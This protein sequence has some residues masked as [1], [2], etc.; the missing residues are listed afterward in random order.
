MPVHHSSVPMSNVEAFCGHQRILID[1]HSIQSSECQ[2]DDWEYENVK[3][4]MWRS[5]MTFVS[6]YFRLVIA[7]K[8]NLSVW[9]I[10]EVHRAQDLHLLGPLYGYAYIPTSRL[11]LEVRIR[12]RSLLRTAGD[13]HVHNKVLK[14]NALT[15]QAARSRRGECLWRAVRSASVIQILVLVYCSNSCFFYDRPVT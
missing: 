11:Q 5:R 14:V 9:N 7:C 6:Y 2:K 8:T 13:F 4:L 12:S 10:V 15:V 3:L 1:W